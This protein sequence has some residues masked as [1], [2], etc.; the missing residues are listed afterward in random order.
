MGWGCCTSGISEKCIFY[1]RILRRIWVEI[2]DFLLWVE[3][4]SQTRVIKICGGARGLSIVIFSSFLIFHTIQAL[5]FLPLFL[6]LLTA[7]P[8]LA[9]LFEFR[10]NRPLFQQHQNLLLL[11]AR[12]LYMYIICRKWQKVIFLNDDDGQRYSDGTNIIQSLLSLPTYGGDKVSDKKKKF[13]SIFS[14]YNA[15][16]NSVSKKWFRAM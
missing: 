14:Q 15:C 7:H 6:K 9:A 13:N 4:F 2:S 10:M 16:L 5:Q 8:D 3:F 1:A 11:S 12:T